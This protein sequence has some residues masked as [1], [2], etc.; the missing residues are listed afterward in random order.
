[1]TETK[2]TKKKA[3]A[4]AA[5]E[6][7]KHPNQLRSLREKGVVLS[8]AEVGKLIGCDEATVSRHETGARSMSRE[9]ILAYAKLYRCETHELFLDLP[10]E[11]EPLT[12]EKYASA[13]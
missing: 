6:P 11:S 2:K 8:M 7:V 12:A 4:T 1:M 5:P 3:K 10:V 9:Q 13:L